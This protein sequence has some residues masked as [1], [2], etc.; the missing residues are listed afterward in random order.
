MLSNYYF[1]ARGV[2]VFDVCEKYTV[3]LWPI[4]LAVMMDAMYNR[5]LNLRCKCENENK[6]VDL[7]GLIYE[8]LTENIGRSDIQNVLITADKICIE[9]LSINNNVQ[10]CYGAHQRSLTVGATRM[11]HF[12]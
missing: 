3:G 1:T 2:C 5:T 10:K 8:I 4:F 6:L 9:S 7:F 11:Q 12:T